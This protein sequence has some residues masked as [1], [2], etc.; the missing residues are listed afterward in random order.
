MND[1][2]LGII[3]AGNLGEAIMAGLI[4]SKSIKAQNIIISNF[5]TYRAE[6]LCKKYRVQSAEN[7]AVI[8]MADIVLLS[9]KPNLLHKMVIDY[10]E[11]Y[12][13]KIVVSVAAGITISSILEHAPFLKLVRTIPNI[14]VRTCSGVFACSYSKNISSEDILKVEG[15]FSKLGLFLNVEESQINAISSIAGAGPAYMYQIIEAM[16]DAGV[17]MGLD[18]A[19]AIAIAAATMSGSGRMVLESKE[20]PAALKDKVTSPAGT[21]IEGLYAIEQGGVRAAIMDAF[22]RAYQK[23]VAFS[24]GK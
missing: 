23:T 3:G 19:S 13:D 16:S 5:E 10:K 8:D 15:L 21:T 6:L 20:H 24:K 11:H 12:K 17:R 2:K 18:R 9:V 22:D 4:S 14:P 1:L 7:S